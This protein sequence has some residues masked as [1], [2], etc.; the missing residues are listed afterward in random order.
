MPDHRRKH[1]T[2]RIRRAE[3]IDVDL[4]VEVTGV[5]AVETLGQHHAGGGK[6]RSALTESRDGRLYRARKLDRVLHMGSRDEDARFCPWDVGD[7]P[8]LR[9]LQPLETAS[10]QRNVG[11]SGKAC[12]RKA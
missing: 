12:T 1:A 2:D 5:H 8:V 3:Q 4:L 7:E 11:A 6:Q 9:K 10:D